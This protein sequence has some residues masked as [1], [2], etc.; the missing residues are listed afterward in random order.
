MTG[1]VF[2]QAL[3]LGGSG[4]VVGA[5]A[6]GAAALFAVPFGL[7]LCAVGWPDLVAPLGFAAGLT[8]TT[9]LVF[10]VNELW[11]SRITR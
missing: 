2:G 4:A 1:I 10:L 8:A 7:A 3:A 11:V 6:A 5:L 9:V